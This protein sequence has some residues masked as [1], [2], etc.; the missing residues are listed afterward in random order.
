MFAY[1]QQLILSQSRDS[2]AH[3][4]S[5]VSALGAPIPRHIEITGP[6]IDPIASGSALIGD[7][8]YR[9]SSISD[10]PTVCDH[11]AVQVSFP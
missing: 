9:I 2:S 11:P 1:F 3:F 4:T 5:S 8:I 6:D 7:I 10:G